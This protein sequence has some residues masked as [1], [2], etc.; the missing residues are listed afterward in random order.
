MDAD[1]NDWS[2]GCKL[3]DCGY[4]EG[5]TGIDYFGGDRGSLGGDVTHWMPD[6]GQEKPEKPHEAVCE[7]LGLLTPKEI[8]FI[9]K[10]LYHMSSMKEFAKLTGLGSASLQRWE[11]GSSMQNPAND[12]YLRL[13]RRYCRMTDTFK[14]LH[15]K[16]EE[17]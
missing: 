2:R 17:E 5:C 7:E 6:T 14:V 1:G 15:S 3:P 9:R 13:L 16:E 12:K 11:S 4:S 10:N 8:T